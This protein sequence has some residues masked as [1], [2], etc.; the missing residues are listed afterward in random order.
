M[1]ILSFATAA[2]ALLFPVTSIAQ[3]SDPT[4]MIVA[5]PV[6]FNQWSRSMTDNI[7]KHLYYPMSFA[8][9]RSPVGIVSV[10]FRCDGTGGVTEV[11]LLKKS[12]NRTLDNAALFAVRKMTSTHP[13]PARFKGNET[14]LANILFATD[15]DEYDRQIRLLHA[16]AIKQNAKSLSPNQPIALNIGLRAGP[17]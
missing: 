6:T 3:T 9:E 5:P 14:F 11:V 2:L 4:I 8:N 12:G 15:R 7:E 17:G 13:M 10:G 1:K 16:A